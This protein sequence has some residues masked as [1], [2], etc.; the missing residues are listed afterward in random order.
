[1]KHHFAY[2]CNICGSEFPTSKGVKMH[3]IKKHRVKNGSKKMAK[4]MNVAPMSC[5]VIDMN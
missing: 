2:E 5:V 4:Y 1:M 3:L